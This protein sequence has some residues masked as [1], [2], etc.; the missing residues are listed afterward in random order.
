MAERR[1]AL[2]QVERHRIVDLGADAAL[3]EALRAR[4]AVR[5]ADDE[6]VVDVA[7]IRRLRPA[8]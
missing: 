1:E 4:V 3:R 2:L 5:H 7:A 6:L 8:A